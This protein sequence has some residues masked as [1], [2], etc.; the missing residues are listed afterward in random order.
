VV[1]EPPSDFRRF[2]WMPT[3]PTQ[4]GL[5]GTLELWRDARLDGEFLAQ[6][7]MTGVFGPGHALPEG[8]SER[9]PNARLVL[10]DEAGQILDSVELDEPLATVSE[11]APWHEVA[12]DTFRDLAD[13]WAATTHRFTRVAGGKLHTSPCATVYQ[14]KQ[15]CGFRVDGLS[16]MRVFRAFYDADGKPVTHLDHIRVGETCKTTS[17]LLRGWAAP[18]WLLYGEE[19]PAL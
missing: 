10:R 12:T 11:G 8:F 4:D 16:T 5:A 18:G 9:P 14:C 6:H 15:R 17:K 2:Q 13:P 3:V 1:R 7:W 19:W